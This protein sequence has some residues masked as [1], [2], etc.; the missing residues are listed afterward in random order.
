M[1]TR[2]YLT[3]SRIIIDKSGSSTLSIPQY[4]AK[5]IF[6]GLAPVNDLYDYSNVKF[7]DTVTASI[8]EDSID[9]IQDSTGASVGD[10][11]QVKDYLSSFFLFSDSYISQKEP[12]TAANQEIMI[13]QN[14]EIKSELL[15]TR[16]TQEDSQDIIK[17]ELEENNKL[18]RKI[19]N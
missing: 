18:L 5:Y 15:S 11:K 7:V 10:N 17:K 13:G 6:F 19:Y 16:I 1:P 9:K 2:V 3:G 14:E 4:R 8:I 12:C